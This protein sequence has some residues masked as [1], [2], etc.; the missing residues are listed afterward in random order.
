MHPALA[1]ARTAL[2]VDRRPLRRDELATLSALPAAEIEALL[3]LASEVR[4]H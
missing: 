3:G 1:L 4:D 2:I